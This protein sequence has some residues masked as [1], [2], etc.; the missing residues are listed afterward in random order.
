MTPL[1]AQTGFRLGEIE[2]LPSR[3]LIRG[4][5]TRVL[6][7]R[8]M[9]VL[10]CLAQRAGQPVSTELLIAEVWSDRVVTQHVAY[11]AIAELR[12]A[13]V[14]VGGPAEVIETIPRRGYRLAVPIRALSAPAAAARSTRWL[15]IASA[16]LLVLAVALLYRPND[17]GQSSSA[18]VPKFRNLITKSGNEWAPAYSADGDWL[19]FN[20]QT[21]TGAHELWLSW[22]RA[23]GSSPQRLMAVS[24]LPGPAVWAPAGRRLAFGSVGEGCLL[25]IVDVSANGRIESPPVQ[26]PVCSMRRPPSV[27]WA[28][29]GQSL[30]Y[31]DQTTE[32]AQSRLRR[33]DLSG[34]ELPFEL[35]APGPGSGD[36]KVL[37]HPASGRI[38]VARNV[39]WT[40]T[41][42]LLVSIDDYSHRS[43]RRVRSEE[44]R[45][46][47]SAAGQILLGTSPRRTDLLD[48]VSGQLSLWV[49]SATRHAEIAA[50]PGR[51][52]YAMTMTSGGVGDIQLAALRSGAA[53]E[54]ANSTAADAQPALANDRLF[55]VS[56]RSGWPE[57]WVSGDG[58]SRPITRFEE[59]SEIGMLRPSANGR[60]LLAFQDDSIILLDVDAEV[61]R[62]VVSPADL[63]PLALTLP[64]FPS[65]SSRPGTIHFSAYDGDSWDVYALDLTTAAEPVPL[66]TRGG[67]VSFS[68]ASGDLY[69]CNADT[70]QLYRRPYQ[71][72]LD[73]PLTL[74]LALPSCWDWTLRGEHIYSV[75][76]SDHHATLVRIDPADQSMSE[77]FQFPAAAAPTA[78]SLSP[79]LEQLAWSHT[80][81][82]STD[83]VELTFAPR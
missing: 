34:A 26:L 36:L 25:H 78:V 77:V 65:W 58:Q 15:A 28:P 20:Y 22:R 17:A 10:V 14:E 52:R 39:E 55:W 35:A 62:T 64:R 70:G 16:A 37:S 12:K 31:T 72:D 63:Q 51:E 74:P 57:I 33:V 75:V 21:E 80:T 83:L 4:T 66:R 1:D 38:M 23:E 71:S 9:D 2:V 29:D 53:L 41:D 19:V 42:V 54:Y 6:E 44:P 82:V 5:T 56:Q 60:Q 67:L 81:P 61:V 48:P 59:M 68:N 27:A 7:A 45:L 24:G 46:A 3:N 18:Q 50:A 8:V 69:Y 40:Q 49:E 73:Q 47:F 30:L 43:M 76:R 13:F 79:D 32:G 11:R